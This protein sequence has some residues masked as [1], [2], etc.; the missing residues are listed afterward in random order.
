MRD[1]A[2]HPT[3]VIVGLNRSGTTALSHAF[4]NHPE[5]E[6]FK[7]PGKYIYESTGAADFSHYFEQPLRPTTKVRVIKQ[8]IGQY[9]PE[10]CTI[11]VYPSG[12]ERPVFLRKLHHIYIIRHP[13][14]IWQSW[15][16]MTHWL[17]STDNEVVTSHWAKI[18][19]NQGIPVGW[20]S[21]SLFH[22]AMCYFK[23]MFEFIRSVA[24]ESTYVI[25]HADLQDKATAER[26]M[27][28]I[29]IEL[30]LPYAQEMI[31]WKIQFGGDSGGRLRDGFNR[32]LDHP[33]RQYIHRSVLASNGLGFTHDAGPGDLP[34]WPDQAMGEELE[35][36]YATML[37]HARGKHGLL[38][39]NT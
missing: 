12:V 27:G 11:P 38:R 29:C 6:L 2:V 16:N 22:L 19:H 39:K 20:G 15:A 17:K 28:S 14:L 21:F 32:P 35:R 37:E 34:P 10:L 4:L 7:D 3:L 33:E 31:D 18:V 36:V 5:I 26:I 30:N 1:L 8:S 9:T 13:R 23:E 25:P 24:P